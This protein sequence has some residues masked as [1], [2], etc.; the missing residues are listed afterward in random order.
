MQKCRIKS[1]KYIGKR[2][3]YN[4]SM[5]SSQ[6]NYFIYDKNAGKSVISANS[7]SV[8]YGINSFISAYLKSNY[9]DEFITSLLNVIITSTGGEKYDKIL[10]FEK[11]FKRKMNI[12]FLERNINNSKLYYTI[13]KKSTCSTEKTEI[14]PSL[15]CKGIG[16]DAAM[17]I[18]KNQPFKNMVEFVNKVDA[19]IVTTRAVS[20][21]ASEGYW[22]NNAK[23]SPE[24]VVKE[25][26][27]IREDIKRVRS[28]G[29]ESNDIFG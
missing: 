28:K 21:L 8:V 29:K 12:K 17:N 1:V 4:L 7:H 10:E 20:A 22:G 24:K 13:E 11:E 16:I 15:L 2:K 14:R 23:K 5:K 19:S 6:H 26:L 9:P 25:F 3:T 27:T 18:E